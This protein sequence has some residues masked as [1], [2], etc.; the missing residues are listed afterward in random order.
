MA[1]NGFFD[2]GVVSSRSGMFVVVDSSADI[3]GPHGY[4]GAQSGTAPTG[5]WKTYCSGNSTEQ[6]SVEG[7]LPLVDP[8]VA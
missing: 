3:V 5:S 4:P 2:F 8:T 7:R 1:P 6:E